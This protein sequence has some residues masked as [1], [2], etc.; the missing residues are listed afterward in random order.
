MI[1]AALLTDEIILT[2]IGTL[3]ML[4]IGVIGFFIKRW[5]DQTDIRE[6]RGVILSEKTNDSLKTLNDTM[7]KINLNLEVYQTTMSTNLTNVKE[8]VDDAHK[9]VEEHEESLQDHEVRIVILEKNKH[10][11]K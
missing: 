5:M 4:F 3:I 9:K 6:E 7:N 10:S 1:L 11:G 2:I 8:K